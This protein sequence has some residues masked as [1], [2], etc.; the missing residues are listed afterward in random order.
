MRSVFV[1]CVLYQSKSR[2]GGFV[3]GRETYGPLVLAEL[4]DCVRVE[5]Y[6]FAD[7]DV[8]KDRGNDAYPREA[9]GPYTVLRS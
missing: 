6:E 1:L 2:S 7:E 3:I 4:R 9:F 5:I 8:E